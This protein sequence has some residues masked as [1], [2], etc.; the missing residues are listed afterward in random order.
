M[1]FFLARLISVALSPV[2]SEKAPAFLIE[3]NKLLSV[4]R[5]VPRL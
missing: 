2:A 1:P 5:V 3:A 4:S